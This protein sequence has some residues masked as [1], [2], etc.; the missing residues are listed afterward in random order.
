MNHKSLRDLLCW[1]RTV[2]VAIKRIYGYA[3]Y[4]NDS[5]GDTHIGDFQFCRIGGYANV[6]EMAAGL[7]GATIYQWHGG[8]L[9]SLL[10]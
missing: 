2:H 3:L 8:D 7:S 9:V 10:I 6:S 4:I 5:E 1:S